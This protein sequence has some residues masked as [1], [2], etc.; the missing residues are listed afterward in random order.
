MCINTTSKNQRRP[1]P[2]TARRPDRFRRAGPQRGLEGAGARA[3][4]QSS[5]VFCT[6][7]WL[8]VKIMVPSW[9]P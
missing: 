6:E 8:V 2:L 3:L 5:E 1:E 7:I 4:G 9:V